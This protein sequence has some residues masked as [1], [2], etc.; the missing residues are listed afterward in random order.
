MENEEIRLKERKS[1]RDF[2][3]Y[4][5]NYVTGI[6]ASFVLGYILSG[7]TEKKDIKLQEMRGKTHYVIPSNIDWGYD[8]LQDLISIDLNGHE[9]P[10]VAFKE[11]GGRVIYLSPEALNERRVLGANDW[12]KIEWNLNRR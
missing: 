1:Q 6:I 8:C 2:Y 3:L 12:G 7:K 4:G 10:L 5:V 11:R 9:R